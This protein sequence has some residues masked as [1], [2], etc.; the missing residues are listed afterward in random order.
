MNFQDWTPVV[1]D[2]RNNR[3]MKAKMNILREFN[4]QVPL[5]F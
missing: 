4:N 3:E 2:K 5:V 1:F